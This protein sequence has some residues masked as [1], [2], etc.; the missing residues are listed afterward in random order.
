MTTKTKLIFEG[1][2]R[3]GRAVQSVK[4][5]LLSVEKAAQSAQRAFLV[6]AGGAALTSL[7]RG[8]AEAGI[9]VDRFERGLRVATGSAAGAAR[10]FAFVSET[11]DRLGLG[12]EATAASYTK[13][14]ASARGTA[15]E[16]KQTREIFL[17]VAE[18]ARVLGL[19][20]DQAQGALTAVEQIISKGKVSA[21]E[22]RGQLGERLPGAFQLAARSIGVTTSELDKMLAAGELLAEDLLPALAVELRETFGPE[23]EAA[24]SDAAASFARFQNSIFNLKNS[25]AESGILDLLGDLAEGARKA[26]IGLG[27]AFLNADATPFQ[28][29]SMTLRRDSRH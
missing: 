17:G 2:D 7:V 11:A 21:E 5:N 28:K 8:V 19:S 25:I 12:I 20:T 6:L 22:L 23:V 1:Q 14:A 27:A 24:A 13:L 26:A 10:E 16:G 18:A 15:L 3:T 4:G 29:E 9:A